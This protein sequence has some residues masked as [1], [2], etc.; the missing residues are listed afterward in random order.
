MMSFFQKAKALDSDDVLAGYRN[1]FYHAEDQ[2]IY[3][4]GNS[5][6]RLPAATALWM[7]DVIKNQWGRDLIQSWNNHWFHLPQQV[8]QRQEA[9][10]L[11]QYSG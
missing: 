2:M 1:E 7:Q 3:L 5:L 8:G 10:F 11:C 6:G 4:D 9:G